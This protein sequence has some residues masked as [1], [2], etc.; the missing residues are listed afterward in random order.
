MKQGT[1]MPLNFIYKTTT[2]NIAAIQSK[3][4]KLEVLCD[5]ISFVNKPYGRES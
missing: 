5:T 2:N 3:S 4:A 1:Q